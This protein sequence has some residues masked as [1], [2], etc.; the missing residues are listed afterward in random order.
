MT[1]AAGGFDLAPNYMRS[2]ETNGTYTVDTTGQ[3]TQVTT[4]Y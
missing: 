2:T 3:V 1:S 4:G